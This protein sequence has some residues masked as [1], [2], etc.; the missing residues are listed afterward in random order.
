MNKRAILFK[1]SYIKH[2]VN[3]FNRQN[4]N[5]NKEKINEVLEQNYELMVI[6]SVLFIGSSKLQNLPKRH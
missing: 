1:L 6:I 3:S 5:I 2:V 4:T